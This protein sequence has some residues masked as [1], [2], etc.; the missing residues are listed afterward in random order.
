MDLVKDIVNVNKRA[1]KLTSKSLIY[2]P[3]LALILIVMSYLEDIIQFILSPNNQSLSF[4]LG[5]V[6]YFV[7]AVFVTFLI[8]ILKNIVLYD[9]FEVKN[10]I[11]NVKD[12]YQQVSSIIF[13][14]II[15]EWIVYFVTS[16][17]DIYLILI[18][19]GYA[20][21]S[22]LYEEVYIANHYAQEA[23]YSIFDFFKSN[24]LQFLPILIIYIF[25]N[26]RFRFSFI[27]LSFVN[28]YFEI[29][30]Y[31]ILLATALIFKGHIFNILY[32][33]N[34]RKR[35]FQGSFR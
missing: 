21:F 10:L 1:L 30:V 16:S 2:V 14:E 34:Y 31:S 25:A 22:T 5:F 33:S 4:V 23:V 24:L 7:R 8:S 27:M 11:S 29:I 32:G 17:L 26:I 35:K 3:I 19:I 13:L 20:I 12:S 15:Y 9:R 6:R 28:N 18:L